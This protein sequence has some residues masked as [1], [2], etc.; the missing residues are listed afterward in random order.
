MACVVDRVEHGLVQLGV[1]I[2]GEKKTTNFRLTD[3]QK[4]IS[5][6]TVSRKP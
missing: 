3:V 4:A 6:T 5:Q 1:P 2:A